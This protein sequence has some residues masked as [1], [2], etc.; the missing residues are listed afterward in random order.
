MNEHT[1]PGVDDLESDSEEAHLLRSP[2]NAKRL[3]A[4]LEHAIA[5]NGQVTSIDE[6]RRSLDADDQA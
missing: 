5:N 6:L 4:A 3:F 1:W 2:T